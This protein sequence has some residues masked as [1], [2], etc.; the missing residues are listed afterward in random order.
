MKCIKNE[1]TEVL[2]NTVRDQQTNDKL[3]TKS[4]YSLGAEIG[5]YIL[6]EYLIKK[7]EINTPMNVTYLGTYVEEKN[8]VVIS[9]KDDYKF[10]GNGIASLFTSVSRG[11]IEFN[12]DRG[13]AALKNTCR[14]MSMPDNSNVDMVIIA[15]S[16]IATGCTAITLAKKAYEKYNPEYLVIVGAFYSDRGVKELRDS[17]RNAII[18]SVGDP[19]ELRSDGMLVPGVGNLDERIKKVV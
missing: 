17:C 14:S 9:T 1:Y 3:L 13:E 2:K 10:F 6:E 4:L 18:I 11:Y 19:D 8:I 5:K 16:V 15:K 12:G 7:K